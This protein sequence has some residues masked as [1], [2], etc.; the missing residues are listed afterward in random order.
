MKFLITRFK[1]VAVSLTLGLALFVVVGVAMATNID[2][3][4][5]GQSGGMAQI[6]CQGGSVCPLLGNPK[7]TTADP[8]ASTTISVERDL[9]VTRTTGSGAVFMYVDN[10]GDNR[11]SMSIDTGSRGEGTITWDGEDNDA[12][13]LDATGLGGVDF[14]PDDGILLAVVDADRRSNISLRVYSDTNNYM[15]LTRAVPGDIITRTD[16]F[17]RFADFSITGGAAVNDIIQNVGAVTLNIDGTIQ[18]GLDIA[19]DFVET[20]AVREYGDLPL[21]YSAADRNASHIPSG[22]RLGELL[23]TESASQ[24]DVNANGDDSTT[25]NDEDGVVR[26]G[27]VI[28]SSGGAGSVDVTIN[29]C[30]TS[31]CRFNM[32]IDWNDDAAL[33]GGSEHIFNDSAQGNGLHTLAF[34]IPATVTINNNSFYIRTRICNTAATCNTTTAADVDDGEIEDYRWGFSPTAIILRI[35]KAY[36]PELGYGLLLAITS[37][38]LFSMYLLF[39]RQRAAGREESVVHD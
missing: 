11:A 10:G 7:A 5:L 2:T 29:G 23:D 33:N 22:T 8:G 39:F 34:S 38:L 27:G 4:N 20:A 14:N 36:S 16:F 6:V 17:F 24:P 12:T 19:L 32:W 31:V 28:W 1:H 37:A 30:P 25:T 15:D 9:E 21:T 13:S 18:D 3:F 26:T 35:Q